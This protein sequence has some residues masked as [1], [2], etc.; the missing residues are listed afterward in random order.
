MTRAECSP[1]EE[2]RDPPRGWRETQTF[3]GPT[4]PSHG[5]GLSLG[6][7][8]AQIRRTLRSGVA[9]TRAASRA[10]IRLLLMMEIVVVRHEGPQPSCRSVLR[11]GD[12]LSLVPRRKEVERVVR[13]GMNQ[14]QVGVVHRQLAETDGAASEVDVV[15]GGAHPRPERIGVVGSAS[16]RAARAAGL[17]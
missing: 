5:H 6:W 16:K 7:V 17:L 3:L 10:E 15:A 4:R 9:P 1:A 8:S 13:V 2:A 14:L 12:E 11:T